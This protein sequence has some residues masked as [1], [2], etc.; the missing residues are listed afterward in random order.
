MI[1]EK[2]RK[3]LGLYNFREQQN[4]TIEQ[5]AF[6]QSVALIQKIFAIDPVIV[7]RPLNV[8]VVQQTSTIL[9]DAWLI[10]I[11]DT[12]FN[13]TFLLDMYTLKLNF[14]GCLDDQETYNKKIA[15]NIKQIQRLDFLCST[16]Q[17]EWHTLLDA[18]RILAVNFV[19]D[20][21]LVIPCNTTM[22]TQFE[23]S[24]RWPGS[25]N[26]L[27][28]GNQMNVKSSYEYITHACVSVDAILKLDHK[29]TLPTAPVLHVIVPL[30]PAQNVLALLVA[31][32]L[33]YNG[34]CVDVLLGTQTIQERLE[35]ACKKQAKY[36]LLLGEEEQK[37]GTVTIKNLMNSTQETIRQ[38]QLIEYLQ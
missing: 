36:L 8:N 5:L 33:H 13:E 18:L 26:V 2:L 15:S 32:L 6:V 35:Q 29:L 16:C 9:A 7:Q 34:R 21:A 12:F 1:L 27:A 23:F 11:L 3:H 24:S 19:I 20:S 38:T 28:H 22:K 30:R 14:L 10:K 4:L 25:I 37:L 17:Q 31:A